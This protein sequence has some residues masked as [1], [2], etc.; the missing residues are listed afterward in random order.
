[1]QLG[2]GHG[3][4]LDALAMLRIFTATTAVFFQLKEKRKKSN[5]KKERKKGK[6]PAHASS[7]GDSR[8]ET[9]ADAVREAGWVAVVCRR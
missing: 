1:M 9:P 7:C 6:Q 8:A 4:E 5:G 2:P 3:L